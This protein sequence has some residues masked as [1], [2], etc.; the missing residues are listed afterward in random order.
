M[1]TNRPLRLFSVLAA[2]ALTSLVGQSATITKLDNTNALGDGTSWSGGTAPV[3]TDIAN[4]SG[5]YNADAAGTNSLRAIMSAAGVSWQGLS[6]GAI[7]GP[8]LTTNTIFAAVTNISAATEAV[9]NGFNVVTIT[10]KANHGFEPGQSVT[11]VGVT[12]AG[13]NG[14]YIVAGVPAAAQ[15]TYTNATGSLA[16]GTAFGTVQSAIYIGGAGTATATSKLTV[17]TSGIDLSAANVS[18]VI[19]D[20][21]NM[22]AGSQTWNVPSG[23]VLRFSN[24]GVTAASARADSTGSDGLIDITGGGVVSLNQGG[25]STGADANSF[26]TFTGSWRVGGGSTLRGIR[27]GATAWGQG[28]ITLNNGTLA[29]GGS[30]SLISSP[31]Y[32]S[33]CLCVRISP[34]S[35][36]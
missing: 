14:T 26:A 33:W 30:R 2:L 10:T 11:I 34:G 18:V 25:G 24:G 1:K 4:W 29:S 6:V 12:P 15:F 22:F 7:S 35:T 13:Y 3:S 36:A 21:T 27:S 31:G 5:T 17:G 28:S 23:R 16:A 32:A 8:A 9:V 19:N 20:N